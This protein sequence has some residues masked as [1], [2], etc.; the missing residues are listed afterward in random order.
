MRH[1]E[2]RL[3]VRV[4]T[5]QRTDLQLLLARKRFPEY[6][7]VVAVRPRPMD[8]TDAD[9]ARLHGVLSC[10]FSVSRSLLLRPSLHEENKPGLT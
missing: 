5:L 1:D 8:A 6:A 10:T 4:M 3:R 2:G 7:Q 9:P